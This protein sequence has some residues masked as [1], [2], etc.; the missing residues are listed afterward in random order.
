MRGDHSV[1]QYWMQQH[2]S[3]IFFTYSG[4]MELTIYAESVTAKLAFFYLFLCTISLFL[5]ALDN[6]SFTSHIG[7]PNKN[8][9]QRRSGPNSSVRVAFKRRR[10]IDI[11]RHVPKP[12]ISNICPNHDP[13]GFSFYTTSKRMRTI[14]QIEEIL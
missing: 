5:R 12:T 10:Q 2:K 4:S 6:D 7:G 13:S 11:D 1:R 8:N 9:L 14:N 3:A